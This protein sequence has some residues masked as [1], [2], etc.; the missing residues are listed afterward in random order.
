MVIL[1]FCSKGDNDKSETV[2]VQFKLL[3]LQE[4][5]TETHRKKGEVGIPS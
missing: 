4:E 3:K 1:L 2:L 5:L